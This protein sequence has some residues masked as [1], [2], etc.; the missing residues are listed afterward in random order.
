MTSVPN[1][2]EP[3]PATAPQPT[4]AVA[5]PSAPTRPRFTGAPVGW[6]IA[7]MLVF[8]PTGIPAL[9]A[10]HRAAQAFGAGDDETAQREAA[11][12]RRWA[13]TSVIVGGCLIAFSILVWIAWVAF[14]LFVAYQIDDGAWTDGPQW[15]NQQS[16]DGPDQP[17][18]PVPPRSGVGG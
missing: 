10:S 11:G 13:V 14:L 12:A 15:S 3:G 7:A 18:L 17:G 2:P 9:L 6:V 1:A 4:H 8:W 5:L 16:F